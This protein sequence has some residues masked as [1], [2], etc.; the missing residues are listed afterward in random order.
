MLPAAVIFPRSTAD[1]VA[2]MRLLDAPPFH[3]VSLTPRGGGTGTN[4]QTLTTGVVI[5]LSR[6]MARILALDDQTVT[7]QPGVV[8]DDLNNYLK[9]HGVFFAP[10]C[11]HRT[12]PRSEA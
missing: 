9:P 6:H 10:A 12:V 4:G 3:T 2:A 1:V 7:V 5:D 8:L 11:R